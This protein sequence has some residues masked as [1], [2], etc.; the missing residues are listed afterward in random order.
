MYIFIVEIWS[1]Y[2]YYSHMRLMNSYSDCLIIY[3]MYMYMYDLA[4]G[5]SNDPQLSTKKEYTHPLY[6]YHSLQGYPILGQMVCAALPGM[7]FE[8]E[9][10]ALWAR[11]LY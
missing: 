3:T 5:R 11:T 6:T 8:E 2:N 4:I 9:S 7:M 1:D 10:M